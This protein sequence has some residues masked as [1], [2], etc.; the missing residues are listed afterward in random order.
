MCLKPGER[1]V[2]VERL[3][4]RDAFVIVEFGLPLRLVQRRDGAADRFPL[5]DRQAGFG[6]AGDAADHDHRDDQAGDDEQPSRHAARAGTGKESGA[7][8]K[9]ARGS[10]ACSRPPTS[11]VETAKTS[12]EVDEC[13]R[14][15]VSR[16]PPMRGGGSTGAAR[17]RP[18][19]EQDAGKRIAPDRIS[20]MSTVHRFFPNRT[21]IFCVPTRHAPSRNQIAI[22]HVHDGREFSM[23]NVTVDIERGVSKAQSSAFGR[24]TPS[25]NSIARSPKRGGRIQATGRAPISLCD[26]TGAMTQSQEVIAALTKIME[27]PIVRSRRVAMYTG[28]VMP[29]MQAVRATRNRPEFRSSPTRTRR[30]PGCLPKR[31]TR[32][33]QPVAA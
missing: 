3:I 22:D 14:Y 10:Y 33:R 13:G 19:T 16:S 12:V 7:G 32:R 1:H 9:H 2:A 26:Y 18:T 6:Q 21:A 8:L 20:H 25:A 31:V 27:N 15:G 29:R 11:G 4:F 5:R 17:G 28:D 30:G 23:F 24:S